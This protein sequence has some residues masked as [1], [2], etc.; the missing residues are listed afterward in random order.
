MSTSNRKKMTCTENGKPPRNVKN[1]RELYLRKKRSKW[2]KSP[3]NCMLFRLLSGPEWMSLISLAEHW[4]YL[5]LKL[6]EQILWI[7]I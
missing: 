6:L 5:A 1:V 7:P 4:L 2:M 3:V